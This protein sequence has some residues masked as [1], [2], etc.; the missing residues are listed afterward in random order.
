M[1]QDLNFP[2]SNQMSADRSNRKEES[3]GDCD[4]P[5]RHTNGHTCTTDCPR[6]HE[7]L[8]GASAAFSSF[9]RVNISR[10]RLSRNDIQAV[11][12][13]IELLVLGC[14]C[15]DDDWFGEAF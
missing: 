5:D 7:I 15:H 9:R 14:I 6:H 4:S 2:T 8:T 11:G 1:S 10:P 3:G 12:V 13:P